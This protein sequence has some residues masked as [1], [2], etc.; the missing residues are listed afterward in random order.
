MFT[1]V[2]SDFTTAMARTEDVAF[3]DHDGE[4]DLDVEIS[5]FNVCAS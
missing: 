2:L 4:E 5:N 1:N 3:D